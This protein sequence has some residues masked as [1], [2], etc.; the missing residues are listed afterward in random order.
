MSPS[1]HCCLSSLR[2]LSTRV[3]ITAHS[4]HTVYTQSAHSLHTVCTQSTHSSKHSGPD[5]ENTRLVYMYSGYCLLVI[6]QISSYVLH[7]MVCVCVC[8]CVLLTVYFLARQDTI[9]WT[10]QGPGAWVLA[11]CVCVCVCVCTLT[12]VRPLM[13]HWRWVVSSTTISP[14][15]GLKEWEKL[16]STDRERE[17]CAQTQVHQKTFINCQ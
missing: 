3:E 9:T 7:V 13:S 8:V 17:R 5:C 10:W 6:S 11:V 1:W 15:T 12:A 4:L 14:R 16:H 2:P